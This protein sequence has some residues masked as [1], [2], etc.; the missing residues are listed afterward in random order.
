VTVSNTDLTKQVNGNGAIAALTTRSWNDTFYGA[1][2]L[3][4]G[5]FLP[6]CNLNDPRANGECGPDANQSFGTSVPN[7]T[8]DPSVTKGWFSRPY[9]LQTS[10]LVQQE[11]RPGLAVRVGYYRT[12]FGNFA[13][14]GTAWSSNGNSQ[15]NNL[16]VGPSDF[17]QYCVTTPRDPRLPGSGGQQVCNY[18]VSPAKFGQ[19]NNLVSQN[20]SYGSWSQVYNGVEAQVN[21]RFSQAGLVTAGFSTGQTHISKCANPNTPGGPL[22]PS[23]VPQMFCDQTIPY[24]GQSQVKVAVNYPL[25]WWHLA[26][27]ANFQNLPGIPVNATW[28]VPNALIVPSLGRNLGACG[29]LAVCTATATVI[30]FEPYT[31]F[32]DRYSLLDLRLS[33]T[34]KVGRWRVTPHMDIY[35][36]LNTITVLSENTAF[37]GSFRKPITTFSGRLFQFGARLDF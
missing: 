37:G 18:D 6:D 5:N 32:E 13:L 19:I 27:S 16:A 7:I 4:S 25:P 29:A 2:D 9:Q 8:F 17:T 33:D 28:A 26:A 23:G 34:I 35:N 10:F 36:V 22:N 20:A 15:V 31:V 14:G 21:A 3:R 30:P 12:S 24:E 11:L 1:G